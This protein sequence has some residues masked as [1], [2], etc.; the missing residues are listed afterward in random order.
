MICNIYAGKCTDPKCQS[1]EISQSQCIPTYL[2]PGQETYYQPPR[3]PFDPCPSL[4]PSSSLKAINR[5][6]FF[7]NYTFSWPVLRALYKWHHF[8]SLFFHSTSWFL[9]SSLLDVSVTGWVSL[10]NSVV[11]CWFTLS[12]VAGRRVVS[13]WGY[14]DQCCDVHSCVS[15]GTRTDAFLFTLE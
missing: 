11:L 8:R 13:W 3:C 10:L 4:L 12:T 6:H 2:T 5:H 9:Y 15:P 7:W 14:W 1:D